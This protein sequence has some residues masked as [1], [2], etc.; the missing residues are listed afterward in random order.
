M[1]HSYSGCKEGNTLSTQLIL[2]PQLLKHFQ[3]P[4]EWYFTFQ[5]CYW[6]Y[7]GCVRVDTC[8]H[9]VV[10]HIR[11]GP[12]VQALPSSLGLWPQRDTGGGD[13]LIYTIAPQGSTKVCKT[14]V[15][16]YYKNCT[17]IIELPYLPPSITQII[18]CFL[19]SG[20]S[21][22]FTSTLLSWMKH[23]FHFCLILWLH[24]FV[25]LPFSVLYQQGCVH[26]NPR[27]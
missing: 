14:F 18:V 24:S 12:P 20:T 7:C 8:N 15:L 19:W 1:L 4:K 6:K 3:N 27:K 10:T 11:Q 26:S 16:V 23:R 22:A 25:Y 13:K 21:S 2:F 9:S 17:A 5:L